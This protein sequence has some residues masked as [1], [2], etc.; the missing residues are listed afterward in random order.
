MTTIL[1]GTTTRRWLSSFYRPRSLLN[2]SV[3][4]LLLMAW[5]SSACAQTLSRL[6]G[7]VITM[8]STPLG[9]AV[10]TL[11]GTDFF[12]RTGSDGRFAI[13]Y[14]IRSAADGGP[15]ISG[16]RTVVSAARYR[17]RRNADGTSRPRRSARGSCR[18]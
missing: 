14:Y 8:D 11:M 9:E 18:R 17:R 15:N 4:T 2:A 7:V 5:P 12:A 3:A 1:H 13:A 6:R 10:V 16:T